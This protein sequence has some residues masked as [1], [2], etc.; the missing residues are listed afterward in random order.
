LGPTTPAY[1]TG[2]APNDASANTNATPTVNIGGQAAKVVNSFLTANNPGFYLVVARTPAT[3]TSGNQNVTVSIGGLTSNAAALPLT[4]GG[5]VSAVTNAATYIDPSLPNGAIAQ[6][7]IAIATGKNLGPVSIVV[8]GKP[9]QNTTLSGTSVAI[10]VGGTTVAGL[11]YYTSF[12]QIAF[13]VPSNTPA[14]TG[15]IT[16]TYAGQ[17]G[18]PSP[19]VITPDNVGIFTVTSDGQGAGIVT[20]GDYSLVSATKAANC[21]GVNTTCGAANPGDVLIIWAPGLGPVNGSDA[22]GAGLGVNMSN[23]P[24]T[25]SLGGVQVQ[26]SYQGRS[27]CCIGEDQ[28][29]F[30]VPANAPLGCAVPL[31]VQ[32]GALIS[33]SVALPIAAAGSRTCTPSNPAFPPAVVV[34]LSTASGP[35]SYADIDLKRQDQSPGFVDKVD[36]EFVR[37]T[38]APAVQPFFI[39][40][41]D[42]PALGTCQIFNNLNGQP[43]APLVPV[44]GLDVGPQITV[45]GPNGSKNVAGSGGTYKGTISANG[46]YLSPGSYTVSA[47][48][49]ADVPKFSAQITIPTTPTMTSPTP[50]APNPTTVTRSNGLTVT[51]TGGQTNEIIQLEGFNATDNTYNVGADLLCTAPATAGTFTIP[52]SV[53]LAMPAGNFGGLI[54]RS[55]VA[56]VSLTGTGLSVAFMNAWYASFAP[57]SFK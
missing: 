44:A 53:L 46:T 10:S 4:N 33:N 49:G 47:P 42:S 9:F 31:S 8:D 6:G 51:W 45:Q 11:M 55:F 38:I 17:A 15:T 5:A 30:T 41:V 3:I 28:I 21:G 36:G 29:V 39:S 1:A 32:I 26:A 54:F 40:Y 35:F 56:P 12:N 20:Y 7:G 22:A 18:A 19:I 16:V 23:I 27:G 52:P 14:G 24:L 50:D 48:G 37:F 13:L 57:L 34:P 2:T 25:I 43:A